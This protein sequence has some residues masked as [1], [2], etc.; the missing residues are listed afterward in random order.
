MKKGKYMLTNDKRAIS[1]LPTGLLSLDHA[2]RTGGMPLGHIVE[3]CGPEESRKTA[4]LYHVIAEAQRLGA[5]C[6]FVGCAHALDQTYAKKIG[7]DIDKLLISRPRSFDEALET[8]DMLTRTSAADLVA[9]D[10]VAALELSAELRFEANS[11]GARLKAQMMSEALGTLANRLDQKPVLCL[12]TTEVEEAGS[13]SRPPGSRALTRYSTQRLDFRRLGVHQH[14]PHVLVDCV[15]VTVVKNTLATPGG[16]AEF[17][18]KVGD[19]ISTSGCVLDLALEH[20]VVS[21]SG[22]HL[23]QGM[24]CLGSERSDVETLLDE[25]PEFRAEIEHQLCVALGIDRKHVVAFGSDDRGT[26]TVARPLDDGLLHMVR[27]IELELDCRQIVDRSKKVAV[28]PTGAL[29]LDIALGIGGYPRGRIVEVFG[30]PDSGTT[31]LVYHVIAE[32]QRLGDVCAFIDV[33]HKIDWGYAERIGVD[34]DALLFWQP[35][36]GEKAL[37]LAD[38]LV[39]LGIDVVAIDSIAALTPRREMEGTL[40]QV[41]FDQQDRLMDRAMRKLVGN[42]GRSQTLCLF[43]NQIRDK[44]GVMFGSPVT[45]PGGWAPKFSSSQRLDVRRLIDL[46]DGSEVVGQRVR[47]KVVK[48]MLAAPRRQAEFDILFGEGISASGCV[49]DLGIE[50]GVLAKWGPSYSFRGICIG[51]TRMQVTDY[52]DKHAGIRAEIEREICETVG[53]DRHPITQF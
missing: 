53:L 42:V 2:L 51:K 43:T 49:L 13:T 30:M 11:I 19:G 35:E 52:L 15:E 24:V 31:T 7:V 20:G 6:A 32:A 17:D 14:G 47:V 25:S 33:E 12:F 16:K 45:Q 38:R 18:I 5:V 9:V 1:V 3:L 48:A 50:H 44:E 21:Q 41:W 46:K 26:R 39:R 27:Q 4:V 22:R 37:E 8:V 23:F 28:I 10:G 34:I 36:D 29:S 40:D